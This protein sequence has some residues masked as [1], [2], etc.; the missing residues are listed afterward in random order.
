MCPVVTQPHTQQGLRLEGRVHIQGQ[1]SICA[2][3][4]PCRV[5]GA[6]IH[7]PHAAPASTAGCPRHLRQ[8]RGPEARSTGRPVPP[9]HHRREGP[10]RGSG[11]E[12]GMNPKEARGQR[13]PGHRLH[14]GGH[15][16]VPTAER[17]HGQETCT[18]DALSNERVHPRGEVSTVMS[19]GE[20]CS[21]N[22]TRGLKIFQ[23]EKSQ[24]KERR[25]AYRWADFH[26]VISHPQQGD[27][28]EHK[29]TCQD[30]TPGALGTARQV[31]RLSHGLCRTINS[32]DS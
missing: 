14:P 28:R 5:A 19:L 8:A 15:Q 25:Q 26:S 4:A 6:G 20:G 31:P 32:L 12:K 1:V 10:Q 13:H 21:P 24:A 30:R 27:T 9:A 22:S 17:P 3:L 7:K 29:H 11:Y 2:D 18:E 23:N 16:A